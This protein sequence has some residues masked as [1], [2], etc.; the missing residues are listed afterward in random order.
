MKVQKKMPVV[1]VLI[2]VIPLLILA[3]IFYFLMSHVSYDKSI[4][5][6]DEAVKPASDYVDSFFKKQ[7]VNILA[8]AKETALINLLKDQQNKEYF[9]TVEGLF[10]YNTMSNSDNQRTELINLEGTIICSSDPAM[11]GVSIKDAISYKELMASEIGVYHHFLKP[12]SENS[13]WRLAAS[14]RVYDADK[15]FIG[16]LQ[17]TIPLDSI[18]EYIG[19]M[20]IGETGQ[21]YL[22]NISNDISY[23][24]DLTE[25]VAGE[26]DPQKIAESKPI[27][28]LL[29][30]ITNRRLNEESGILTYDYGQAAVLAS[31]QVLS[32]PHCVIVAQMELSEVYYEVNSFQNILLISTLIIGLICLFLGNRTVE[33]IIKPLNYLSTKIHQI[34]EGDLSVRCNIQGDDEFHDLAMSINKMAENLES[35]KLEL[36]KTNLLLQ[37]SAYLDPLTNLSNRKS[38]YHTIDSHFRKEDRQA[39]ILFDLKGFKSIN[40]TFGNHMGD[41]VLFSV[42]NVLRQFNSNTLSSARLGGDEFLVFVSAYASPQEIIQI[43]ESIIDAIENIKVVKD[44]PIN[45]SVSMGISFLR[46]GTLNRRDWIFQADEAMRLAKKADVSQYEI[47][48]DEYQ[49]LKTDSSD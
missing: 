15:K 42:G 48:E 6:L 46:S 3:S 44:N 12:D 47:Y 20:H 9:K 36:V 13:L 31:Y 1:M 8:S 30:D 23:G 24:E 49:Y 38:I 2:V 4:I 45:L 11:N 32:S 33:M 17:R 14:T 22:L 26:V 29:S 21:V 27:T 34:E 43:T 28:K 41:A 5:L 18:V 25:V 39:I 40:D 7:D 19:H 16:I 37:K 10:Q 35:R